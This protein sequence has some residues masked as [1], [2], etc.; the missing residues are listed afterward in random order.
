MGYTHYFYTKLELNKDDFKK[1]VADFIKMLKPLQHL[2][3]L[4][5]NGHGEGLPIINDSEIIFNGIRNCGHQD[6]EL[7]ITWPSDNAKGISR[8]DMQHRRG[9][10][11][12]MDI[13]GQWYAGLKL[14]TRSCDG[15]CSHETFALELKPEIPEYRKEESEREELT[16]NF[17]KTAYKPY[18]LAVN[19]ALIIA[20]HHLKDQIFVNS[21]GEISQWQD[22]IDLCDHFL[23]YGKD[24]GFKEKPKVKPKE[25]TI[26]TT[27]DNKIKLGDVF[28]SSWGYDQTNI[29]YYKVVSISASGK[30]C[31]IVPINSKKLEDVGFMAERV[32]PN[33]DSIKYDRQWNEDRTYKD[34]RKEYRAIIKLDKANKIW[35]RCGQTYGG[36]LR[37]YDGP[38]T[39]THYA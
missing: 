28:Y 22:A 15:N 20:D 32:V 31:K 36:Y 18:D 4:I 6:R 34:V 10:D 16:F 27:Q 17:C 30:T 39:A 24:F 26:Q 37:V 2:G 23:G 9:N 19:V 21:D 29:D 5:A 13:D 8:L 1:V 3:S 33:L 12:K 11:S 25:L 14:S 38:N 35:L 7:G